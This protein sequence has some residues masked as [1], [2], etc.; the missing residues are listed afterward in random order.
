[1]CEIC[2]SL[3]KKWLDIEADFYKKTNEVNKDTISC[4]CGCDDECMEDCDCG[5]RYAE[6]EC[7]D[8]D[9]N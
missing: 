4:D 8:C 5:D 6:C 1:M 3:H 7:L 2:D 9:C